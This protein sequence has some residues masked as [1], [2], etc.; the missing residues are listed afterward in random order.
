MLPSDQYV[1]LPR[2]GESV[3]LT[4][5]GDASFQSHPSKEAH[6]RRKENRARESAD[7]GR[8]RGEPVSEEICHANESNRSWIEDVR[9]FTATCAMRDTPTL[10]NSVGCR[11]SDLLC[12]R[13][14][15]KPRVR[16]K[17]KRTARTT[18]CTGMGVTGYLRL[19]G[20]S[21]YRLTL[22]VVQHF[23]QGASQSCYPKGLGNKRH[24]LVEEVSGV[25][26]LKISRRIP[27]VA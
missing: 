7:C 21:T 1:V 10:E 27:N 11:F 23:P 5:G 15:T 2:T 25:H 20:K 8:A 3:P 26:H 12:D 18:G 14:R 24:I 22:I 6:R 16:A 13:W 4:L 9:L 19:A 17:K